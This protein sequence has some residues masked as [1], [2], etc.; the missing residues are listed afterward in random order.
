MSKLTKNNT[1]YR[2]NSI[3]LHELYKKKKRKLYS[4]IR[5]NH[6]KEPLI[7][8][9]FKTTTIILHNTYKK[10]YLTQSMSLIKN[11]Q[12]KID[13][14]DFIHVFNTSFGPIIIRQKRVK[15]FNVVWNQN[16]KVAWEVFSYIDVYITS[17]H[18]LCEIYLTMKHFKKWDGWNEDDKLNK[19]LN[20]NTTKIW[21]MI[22]TLTNDC[23]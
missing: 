14:N 15:H 22:I 3:T 12:I 2:T 18:L 19:C 6:H 13:N 20:G 9:S 7:E 11:M 23:M 8:T 17:Y 5:T 16:Y 1:N 4:N 21:S 10:N